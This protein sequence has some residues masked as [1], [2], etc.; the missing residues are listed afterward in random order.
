M[1]PELLLGLAAIAACL[2]A[3]LT[4]VALRKLLPLFA[5]YA[6][7]RPNARSSHKVPTPQGAGIVIIIIW[8]ALL[9]LLAIGVDLGSY[10]LSTIALTAGA[11]GLMLLGWRDDLVPLS[12]QLRLGV[13]ALCAA[14]VLVMMPSE[15]RVLGEAVPLMLERVIAL[16]AMLWIINLTNFIDGMDTITISWM[17]PLLTG[18]AWMASIG[19]IPVVAGLVA[20]ILMGA[21]LG[22]WPLNRSPAR[23]FLGDAGALPLG[24]IAAWLLYIIASEVSI[25]AA[26]LMGAYPIFDATLTLARRIKRG[27]KLSEAHRDHLYQHLLDASFPAQWISVA[28]ALAQTL[29]MALATLLMDASWEVNTAVVVLVLMA[30]SVAAH[31]ILT[32]YPKAPA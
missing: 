16:I 9:L 14:L 25:T 32:R 26:M 30:Y 10:V 19:H 18:S 21:M 27:A 24:L 17:L 1:W 31:R 13:Q 12:A 22:F 20:L 6:M 7:A 15:W 4:F 3:T 2:A 23:L 5:N 28:I 29:T 11:W 8:A